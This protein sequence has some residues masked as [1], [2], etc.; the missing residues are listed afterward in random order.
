M[1]YW[2]CVDKMSASIQV[3]TVFCFYKMK[4]D[5]DTTEVF[6]IMGPYMLA[7]GIYEDMI[8]CELFL[9][10]LKKLSVIIVITESIFWRKYQK[11]GHSFCGVFLHTFTV[12]PCLIIPLELHFFLENCIH[13]TIC[14]N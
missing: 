12:N 9:K 8:I 10:P 7:V 14:S 3:M 11:I 1:S 5:N 4:R 6:H 2:H 13:R